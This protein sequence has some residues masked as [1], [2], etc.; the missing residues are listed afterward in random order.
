MVIVGK[1]FQSHLPVLRDL[2][3][4]I[5]VPTFCTASKK[6]TPLSLLPPTLTSQPQPME[7]GTTLSPVFATL[8]KN[9]GVG[10]RNRRPTTVS[11]LIVVGSIAAHPTIVPLRAHS[12]ARNSNRFIRLLHGSLYTRGWGVPGAFLYPS[13]RQPGVSSTSRLSLR[14]KRGRNIQLLPW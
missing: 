11:S 14:Q 7:N 2:C 3:V 6:S 12:D 9:M 13:A 8:T 5:P 10:V 1:R 4:E